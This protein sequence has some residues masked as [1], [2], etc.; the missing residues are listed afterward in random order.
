METGIMYL[1]NIWDLEEFYLL[2]IMPCSAFKVSRHFGGICRLH[3][4]GRRISQ[5]RNQRESRWQAERHVPPKLRLT[6]NE[7]HDIISQNIQ[8]FITTAVTTS[9]RTIGIFLQLRDSA[10]FR[11]NIETEKYHETRQLSY[12]GWQGTK[13]VY[14]QRGSW[15]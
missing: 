13:H 15:L 6:F 7:L 1:T 14:S 5:A 11:S 10:L 2:G 8:L 12:S 4:Q 3:L 9:N